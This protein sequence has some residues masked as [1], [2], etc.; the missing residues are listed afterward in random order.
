M[1][2]KNIIGLL[3][4]GLAVYWYKQELDAEY[5]ELRKQAED[6]NNVLLDELAEAK[7]K[8]NPNGSADQA[9]LVMTGTVRF[10]GLTLNQL[11]VW[12]NIKNYSDHKVEIGDIQSRLW[13]GNTRS[14]RVIPSNNGNWVIPAGG[15]IRVRLYARGDVA[16]PNGDHKQVK[17]NLCRIAGI[18]KIKDGAIISLKKEPAL[19][20]LQYLWNWS[21]GETECFVY[22]VPCD[23]EYRFAGWTVGGYEGYNAGNENQ[24][25]RNPSYWAN[26]D[27]LEKDE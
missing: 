27:E 11:E 26:T 6:L 12:L 14:E 24:Q 3:A 7:A 9:P 23:F 18:S 1:S 4:G 22:D 19:L 2:I 15:T 21:G 20:D 25:K 5:Q 10:G 16:Y 17:N 8:V 13:V